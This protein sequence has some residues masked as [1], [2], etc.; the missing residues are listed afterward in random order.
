MGIRGNANTGVTTLER[1]KLKT[2]L[3]SCLQLQLKR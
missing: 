2:E 1:A 3:E